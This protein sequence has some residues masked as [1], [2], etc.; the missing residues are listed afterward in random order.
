MAE[1]V[2]GAAKVMAARPLVAAGNMTRAG[3]PITL[4]W[5]ADRQKRAPDGDLSER[6]HSGARPVRPVERDDGALVEFRLA[7]PKDA[8]EC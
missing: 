2:P 1:V 6:Q 4:M 7:I 3:H 8:E 5:K